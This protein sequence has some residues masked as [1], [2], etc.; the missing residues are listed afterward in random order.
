ME[1][2]MSRYLS[3]VSTALVG[4]LLVSTA[5]AV[6]TLT[7]TAE[8]A[9]VRAKPG[10]THAVLTVVSQGAI[11][12][13]LETQEAWYKILLEDGREG[14]ITREV[15]RVEQEER[16]LNVVAPQPAPPAAP[17]APNRWALVIGNGA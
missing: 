10:M 12:P 16:K 5:W 15:G 1:H 3:F 9:I 14:W 2:A 8:Q 11:F 13:I 6:E 4:L 7:I 17:M